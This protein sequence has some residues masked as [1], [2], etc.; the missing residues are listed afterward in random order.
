[1]KDR[2]QLDRFREFSRDL[3]IEVRKTSGEATCAAADPYYER[4]RV[5]QEREAET[6]ASLTNW[7]LAE[8][9]E[10]MRLGSNRGP[11]SRAPWWERIWAE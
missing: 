11:R 3:S 8:I 7:D 1:M 6:L 5:R 10:K 4:V 9:R 2:E